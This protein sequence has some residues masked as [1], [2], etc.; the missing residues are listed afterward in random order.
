[1]DRSKILDHFI[2]LWDHRFLSH[3]GRPSQKLFAEDAPVRAVAIAPS[4][5]VNDTCRG[6]Q[7]E[8]FWGDDQHTEVT[9][10]EL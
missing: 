6:E 10:D 3:E 7:M 1:M 4:R 8:L 2:Q 5:L 9:G